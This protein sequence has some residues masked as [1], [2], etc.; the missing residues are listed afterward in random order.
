MQCSALFCEREHGADLSQGTL[1]PALP[2][3]P[4][5]EGE[6]LDGSKATDSPLLF[7]GLNSYNPANTEQVGFLAPHI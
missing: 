6:F 7:V 1:A 3:L 4:L 2:W 5:C